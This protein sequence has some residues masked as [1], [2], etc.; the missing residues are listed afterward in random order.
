[1]QSLFATTCELAGIRVPDSVQFPSIAPL[2]KGNRLKQ[3]SALYGAFLNL[4]RS[5][6]TSEWKLIRTP[7]EGLVQL[8]HVRRDPWE[9]HN[10]A[11]DPHY[12]SRLHEMD[13]QLRALMIEMKDL[14]A[15]DQVAR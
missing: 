11:L 13:S 2:L 4:Q 15:W 6:R 5:V 12:H 1:M 10:L 3:Q 14:M 8:F 9:I 7:A